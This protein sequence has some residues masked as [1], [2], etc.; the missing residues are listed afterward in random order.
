M[1][2]TGPWRFL[3]GASLLAFVIVSGCTTSNREPPAR[4][5]I[6]NLRLDPPNSGGPAAGACLLAVGQVTN[7]SIGQDLVPSPRCLVIHHDQQ[8]SVTNETGHPITP[9]LGTHMRA[10]VAA[11]QTYTFPVA[12]GTYLAPGV[13]RLVFTAYSAAGIWVDAVCRGPGAT[14]CATT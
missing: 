10:S 1:V 12:V 6:T 4:T 13:H 14:E 3:V 9:T 7:I 11:G 5:T 8:I 2:R